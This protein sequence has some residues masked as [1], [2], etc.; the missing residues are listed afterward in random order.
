M[1]NFRNFGKSKKKNEDK[2]FTLDSK[3]NEMMKKFEDTKKTLPELKKKFVEIAEEYKGYKNISKI[4]MS[5]LDIDRKFK[6]KKELKELKNK[7]NS[8]ENNENIIDYYLKV[9][10]FLHDYY[11]NKNRSEKTMKEFVLNNNTKSTKTNTKKK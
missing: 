1:F 10:V 6:L 2:R 7:I 9:G 4:E 5:N 8:I 11:E 3:H